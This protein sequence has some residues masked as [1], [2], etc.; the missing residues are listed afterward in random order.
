[1]R[2]IPKRFW[3][4]RFIL[5]TFGT[6][7]SLIIAAGLAF[8]RYSPAGYSQGASCALCRM[9]RSDMTLFGS[10]RTTYH[11]NDFSRWYAARIEPRH[12]HIWEPYSNVAELNAFGKT[13]GG[14]TGRHASIPIRLLSE[15]EHRRFLE[16]VTNPVALEDLFAEVHASAAKAVD[17][18]IEDGKGF[19]IVDAIRHWQWAGYP[20]NWDDWWARWW[21]DWAS[22]MK[23]P[24][25]RDFS[26]WQDLRSKERRRAEK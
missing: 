12:T 19:V 11:E 13:I 25:N 3:S 15:S 14:G 16:H 17:D 10:P 23:S 2:T 6:L 18:P 7:A 1:M 9:G 26:R 8:I 24:G 5:A 22:W 4:K 21:D 20:G